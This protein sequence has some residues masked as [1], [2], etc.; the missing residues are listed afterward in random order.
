MR[1]SDMNKDE[2]FKLEG[3]DMRETH[4]LRHYYISSFVD[5]LAN[6]VPGGRRSRQNEA[7]AQKAADSARQ[8]GKCW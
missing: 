3:Q 5:E 1:R 8:A 4:E 7:D 6:L 2:R